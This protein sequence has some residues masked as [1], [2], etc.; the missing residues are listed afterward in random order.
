MRS[1]TEEDVVN[2]WLPHVVQIC[3]SSY[4]GM[5]LEDRLM[6]G[7]IALL[8]AIRTYKTQYGCFEEY[9]FQQ[10]LAIMKQ[11]NK[12]AWAARK[13][14]SLFSLDAGLG[15]DSSTFALS[16]YIEAPPLDDTVFDVKR[17]IE[18][19]S[20]IERTI[21]IHL[22]KGYSVSALSNE[23]VFSV[24]KIQSVIERL[25]NKAAAYFLT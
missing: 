23:L 8:H 20:K 19:L 7:K 12:Q 2:S 9:M 3:K 22:M 6:E 16:Q 4:K 13:L 14:D 18:G 15:A 17:F 21:I 10:I 25:Q 24:D 11:K 5:E 1:I